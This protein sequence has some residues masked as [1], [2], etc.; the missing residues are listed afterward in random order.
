MAS[1]RAPIRHV[2]VALASR[3]RFL[4][5]HTTQKPRRDA[6]AAK[7]GVPSW[8]RRILVFLPELL[9]TSGSR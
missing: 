1:A 5:L 6:G 8:I 9:R 3:R 4:N 7:T 2:F